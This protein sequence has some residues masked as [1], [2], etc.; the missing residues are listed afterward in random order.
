MVSLLP[1]GK[2]KAL[3]IGEVGERAVADAGKQLL[4]F[5]VDGIGLVKAHGPFL[6]VFVDVRP[7]CSVEVSTANGG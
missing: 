4:P 1:V 2:E 3:G 6:K 7:E 5:D